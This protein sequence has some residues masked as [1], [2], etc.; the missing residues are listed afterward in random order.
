MLDGAQGPDYCLS[1]M[2]R[3][4]AEED[5]EMGEQTNSS[6]IRLWA[7]GQRIEMAW[8]RGEGDQRQRGWLRDDGFEEAWTGVQS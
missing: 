7:V 6:G 3:G 8:D 4:A 5:A 1:Q 2:Q